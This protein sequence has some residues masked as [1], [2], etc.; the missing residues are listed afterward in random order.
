MTNDQLQTIIDYI[1][2][3]LCYGDESLAIRVAYTADEKELETHDV[4]IVPNG[5]FGISIV[6]PDLKPVV[7]EHPAKNKAIIRTDIVYNT[8]FFTSRAEETFN[9]E[10]DEHG[11]FTAQFSLLGHKNLLL[12][13]S[14]D[15]HARLLLKLLNAPLPEPGFNRIY[16]THDIDILTKYRF[17]RGALGGIKR[18]EF[19]QVIKARRDIHDDPYYTYPWMVRQDTSVPNAQMLYFVKFT[20]GKGYD[21]PQYDL[22]GKDFYRIYDRLADHGAQFGIHSSYYGELRHIKYQLNDFRYTFHRSHF[23]RGGI[24]FFKKLVNKGFTDDFTM[25]FA[26]HVGFR[27]QTTRAVRWINPLNYRL[28][29]L[30]LHPLNIMDCTLSDPK[31]MNLSEDEAYFVC[32]QLID[33]VRMHH[34]DLCLLWHNHM[35]TPDTYHKSLYSKV[36]KL[37]Q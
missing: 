27:L 29:D 36:L 32:E 31:Y 16:L 21:Y 4:I 22:Q 14:L 33:K 25:G 1:I 26:D 7:V 15:E 9:T 34:G 23:L 11:R 18:G 10:R 37:L 28:T 3:W 35:F 17:F 6:M 2:Q 12:I 5:L 13:P 24:T 20:E 30:V 19:Q 8:F